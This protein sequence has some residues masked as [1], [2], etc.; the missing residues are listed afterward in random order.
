MKN[1]GIVALGL[2]VVVLIFIGMSFM[3]QSNQSTNVETYTSFDKE[4]FVRDHSTSF[5]ENK[6]NVIVVE[7]LDPQCEACA[8]FHHAVKDVYKEYYED[9]KLVIRYLPNQKNS[10]FTVKLL[11]AAKQQNKYHEVLETIFTT[12][13]KWSIYKNEKPYLLWDF[14]KEIEGLD[15]KKFKTDFNNLNLRKQL[16]LDREDAN[17]LKVR[18][19]PSFFVNGEELKEFSP[20]GLMDLVESKI[21]K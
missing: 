17:T 18:G 14:I 7:F 12:R 13:D 10:L 4:P 21:Y 8:A 16:V 5:G 6:K 9:I 3:F 1:K 20:K 2:G 11:E 15:M 19:T